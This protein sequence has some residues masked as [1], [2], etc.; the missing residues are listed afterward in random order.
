M[1]FLS[2]FLEA[3]KVKFV[4]NSG[5][6]RVCVGRSMKPI[7]CSSEISSSHAFVVW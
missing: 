7:F 3:L 5:N 2:I 4:S 6:G 1:D